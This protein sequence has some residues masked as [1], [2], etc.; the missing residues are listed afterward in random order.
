M[1][2]EID[3]RYIAIQSLKAIVGYLIGILFVLYFLDLE[4]PLG[5]IMVSLSASAFL[6]FIFIYPRNIYVKKDFICFVKEN[7]FKRSKVELS[8][9][10]KIKTNYKLYN[11]ILLTT[12][13]GKKIRLHPKD[14]QIL[15]HIIF[16]RKQT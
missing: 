6:F 10:I 3:R 15:E 12:K 14:V 4:E 11:T 8:D 2:L 7:S 9:I 13:S 16:S 1:E 5:F